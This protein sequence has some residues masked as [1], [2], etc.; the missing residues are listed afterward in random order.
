MRGI[1]LPPGSF[2]NATRTT[3]GTLFTIPAGK[4][5]S[6][7]CVLSGSITL[8]GNCNPRVTV[9]GTNAEPPNGSTVHQLMLT[10]LALTTASN[11]STVDL[12]VRA[13]AGNNVTLEFSAGDVGQS[14]VTLNGF[15]Y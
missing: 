6:A 13:P 14:S 10:G 11:S 12:I 4:T 2:V 9:A 15:I 1:L 5:L 7:S 3:S 8:A